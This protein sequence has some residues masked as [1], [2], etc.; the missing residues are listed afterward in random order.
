MLFYL[1]KLTN[2]SSKGVMKKVYLFLFVFIAIVC[3]SQNGRMKVNTFNTPLLTLS[4]A[5]A[6][7]SNGTLPSITN[8][9]LTVTDNSAGEAR[10]AN[11]WLNYT[12]TASGNKSADGLAVVIHN[13]PRGI[14]AVGGCGGSLGCGVLDSYCGSYGSK[15]TPSIDFEMNLYTSNTKGIILNTNGNIKGYVATGTL[16]IAS[17]NPI[18]VL[19][20]YNA[21]TT[22]L[23]VILTDN[24]AGTSWTATYTVNISTVV[25][26][27]AY[28]TFSGGAGSL[29][30]TQ[31]I[32]KVYFRGAKG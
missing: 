21:T 5:M 9:V 24:V 2:G 28:L 31:T 27:S 29:T 11:W 19:M 10:S 26:A 20:K 25:G 3:Q 6:F 14:A 17:G 22:T 15:I 12:Y 13:D 30:A 23:T 1:E 4:S 32:S 8:G 16:D 18:D 7:N